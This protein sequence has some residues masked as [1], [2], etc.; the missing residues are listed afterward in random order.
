VQGFFIERVI[1]V[2]SPT[3]PGSSYFL[4][5]IT[6]NPKKFSWVQRKE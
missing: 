4:P 1:Q 5:F 2:L 6:K 3:S